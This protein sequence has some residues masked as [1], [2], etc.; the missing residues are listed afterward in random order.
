MRFGPAGWSTARQDARSRPARAGS[1]RRPRARTRRRAAAASPH[2]RGGR[3]RPRACWRPGT[4]EPPPSWCRCAG[5]VP[6]GSGGAAG[7]VVGLSRRRHGG[8]VL[9]NS[10]WISS[11]PSAGS[12]A[13]SVPPR[14]RGRRRSVAVRSGG[15]GPSSADEAA[16]PAQGRVGGDQAMATQCGGQPLDGGGEHGPVDPVH[17]RS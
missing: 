16:V 1:G 12:P 4:Q 3:N 9:S 5:A 2:S 17:A 13:P 6:V 11:T 7:S 15:V 10:P 8:R 14:R